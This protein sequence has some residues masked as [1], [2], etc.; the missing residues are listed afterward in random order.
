[1]NDSPLHSIIADEIRQHGSL[2][3][4]RYMEFCLMHPQYGYY[5]Q[6]NPIGAHGDFIT[7]PEISQLFGEMLAIWLVQTWEQLGNP[8]SVQLAELGP[9]RGT[10]MRNILTV[11]HNKLPIEAVHLVEQ[12][13]EL[14]ALQK[15]RLE[16]FNIPCFWH[17]DVQQLEH[18]HNYLI[19]ANEFFDALPIHQYVKK[20][21]TWHER[22]VALTADNQFEETFVALKTATPPHLPA[23]HNSD[24]YEYSPVSIEVTTQLCAHIQSS[25][26]AALIIDYGYEAGEM[27]DTLQAVKQH[28]YVDVFA[29]CGE[30]DLTAHVDFAAL[31]AAANHTGTQ[32]FG[33]I[34]QGQLLQQLG[35]GLR[36]QLAMQQQPNHAKQLLEST[37]RLIAPA[38]MGELFKAIA[39]LPPNNEAPYGF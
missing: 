31:M 17:G 19:V 26:S 39:I 8:S 1:M 24:F 30:V 12:N 25:H 4:A 23:H 28:H 29:N 33:A 20:D 9:G 7:A 21:D 38:Q 36:T 27:K 37:A 16:Q 2:S 13:T 18:G 32:A 22:C 3:I 34:T 10:L 15:E 6:R 35:I 11:L 14:K 5:Q